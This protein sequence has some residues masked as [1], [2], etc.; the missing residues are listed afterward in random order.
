M[1]QIKEV[2][3]DRLAWEMTSWTSLRLVVDQRMAVVPTALKSFG[4]NVF[5]F[6][7]QETS[8]GW[9][10]SETRSTE[11]GKGVLHYLFAF[12]GR[13]YVTVKYE[14][15]NPEKQIWYAHGG[16]MFGRE[17]NLSGT[18][19]PRPLYYYF[20]GKIPLH[21]A[22]V[23][24]QYIG[25]EVINGINCDVLLFRNTSAYKK[26]GNLRVALDARSSAPVGFYFGRSIEQR[27]LEMGG[28]KGC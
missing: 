10:R 1:D 4:D 22:L 11:N 23:D 12:D 21:E 27:P 8:L 3:I 18:E 16:Q 15:G 26:P 6:E 7:Y 24:A 13:D 20:V 25:Q 9:R 28:A 19:R 5:L 14:N 17:R 2:I